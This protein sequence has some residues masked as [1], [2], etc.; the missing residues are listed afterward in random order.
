MAILLKDDHEVEIMGPTFGDGLYNILPDN[1][2]IKTINASP[3][4]PLPLTLFDKIPKKI[5]SDIII[6]SK[7]RISSFGIGLHVKNTHNI[8]LLLDIDEWDLGFRLNNGLIKALAFSIPS[9]IHINSYFW[10]KIMEKLVNKADLITVNNTWLQNK[11]GGKQIPHVRDD[12]VWNPELYDKK[13]ARKL[14]NLD[15]NNKII[16]FFGKPLPHKG[17]QDLIAA[18]EM[19]DDP[20]VNLHIVGAPP[21]FSDSLNQFDKRNHIVTHQ[22]V[23]FNRAP[24]W[25]TAADIMVAPQR[26]QPSSH[27]QVPA[28]IMDCLA[29][30]KPLVTTNVGSI[31]D[32]VGDAALISRPSNPA[33][34]Y[35][36]INSLLVD[37]ELCSTLGE[38][39]RQRYIDNF[40]NRIL[41]N[42]LLD[43]INGLEK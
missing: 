38:R 2:T 43:C 25:V 7:L 10:L 42:H 3:I 15:S 16:M 4:L 32:V 6:A 31:P 5:N 41:R 24:L 30:G 20:Y 13:Q 40:S 17:I 39:A 23:H 19:I 37:E 21:E 35:E 33:S 1:V 12:K 28:K 27:G 9:I 11:F 8:P 14:L 22:K 36:N 18:F 26:D 34:L 29:M